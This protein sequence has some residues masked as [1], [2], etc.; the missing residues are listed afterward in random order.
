MSNQL[1]QLLPHKTASSNQFNCYAYVA[2]KDR[3]CARINS[4]QAY[5]DVN[6]DVCMMMI[7]GFML[8]HA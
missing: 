2:S 1:L 4:V 6:H 7:H 5:N 3:Y 8:I